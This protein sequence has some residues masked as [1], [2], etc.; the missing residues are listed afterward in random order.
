MKGANLSH[1]LSRTT[2]CGRIL[3]VCVYSVCVYLEDGLDDV[4]GDKDV[5]DVLEGLASCVVSCQQLCDGAAA[6]D[7]DDSEECPFEEGEVDQEVGEEAAALGGGWV[8]IRGSL[9][10][11]RLQQPLTLCV[12]ACVCV[13]WWM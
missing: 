6:I 13:Q 11:P 2:V 4:D 7:G 9:L 3:L 8:G 5:V 12:C 1:T 10:L